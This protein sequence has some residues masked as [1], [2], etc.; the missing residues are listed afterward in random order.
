MY[1]RQA[2]DVLEGLIPVGEDIK[3]LNTKTLEKLIVFSIMWSLGAMLELDDRKKVKIMIVVYV[4][5]YIK[6][7]GHESRLYS[8]STQSHLTTCYASRHY[9]TGRVISPEGIG[10]YLLPVKGEDDI[11]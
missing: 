3:Q 11:F 5:T 1:V 10:L 6:H 7:S 8:L 2:L 4:W 9:A